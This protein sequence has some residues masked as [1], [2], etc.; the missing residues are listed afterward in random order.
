MAMQGKTIQRARGERRS[1]RRGEAVTGVDM[2]EPQDGSTGTPESPEP[3]WSVLD[4]EDKK[5]FFAV[6]CH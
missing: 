6:L 1:K 4:F 5:A 2:M 3:T